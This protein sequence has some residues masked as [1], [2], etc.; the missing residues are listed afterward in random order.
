[1]LPDQLN[2]TLPERDNAKPQLSTMSVEPEI[3]VMLLS[4]S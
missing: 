1:M 2:E 4:T 3:K